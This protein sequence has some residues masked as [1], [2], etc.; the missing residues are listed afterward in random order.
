[1]KNKTN[2]ILD[3]SNL[4]HRTY[5]ISQKQL[6]KEGAD[7]IAIGIFTFLRT[8]KSYV[9]DFQTESVY[10]A[11]DKKL[12]WPS[13]N[14]RKQLLEGTYKAGR[15][16]SHA[17]DVH[18]IEDKLIPVL[19]SLGIHNFFP[20]VLEADD[21]VSYLSKNLEGKNIVISVDQDLIQLVDENTHFY[22]PTKKHTITLE[23]FEEIVGVKHANYVTY[24]AILGDTADNIPGLP[25]YGKVRSKKLAEKMGSDVDKTVI[26]EEFQ[27]IVDKNVK[28]M[29]LSNSWELE[30]GEEEAYKEQLEKTK[31]QISNFDKFKEYC[32]KYEYNSILKNL[33]EWRSCFNKYD[34]TGRKLVD[35]I[36][37]L[38]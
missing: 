2:L 18:D 11:W 6:K 19:E 33:H 30:E 14:Y 9:K 15:D 22:S 10:I 12:K 5:W 25:G 16:K 32:E 3:G 31:S 13:T 29:D 21:I 20:Y 37:S 17:H 8:L 36:N 35:L 34:Q 23:N 4:L 38:K 27:Q 1:M 24:K 26:T 7:P 28:L